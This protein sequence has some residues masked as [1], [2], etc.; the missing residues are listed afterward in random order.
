MPVTEI[1]FIVQVTSHQW[2]TR[3]FLGW[4]TRIEYLDPLQYLS[5]IAVVRS[6]ITD[7]T[8]TQCAWN[9]WAKL[10]S[11]PAK[12]S[13]FIQQPRPA[14]ARLSNQQCRPI[15]MILNAI[16]IQGNTSDNP[17]HTCISI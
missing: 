3:L 8:A 6:G 9:T 13:Q 12:G 16:G 5:Q 10:Q 11:S 17:A 1:Q 14:D 15:S 7:N 2:N 4:L